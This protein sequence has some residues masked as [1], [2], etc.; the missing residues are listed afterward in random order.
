MQLYLPLTK[1]PQPGPRRELYQQFED[2]L[3]NVPGLEA[4]AVATSPP[5]GGGFGRGLAL[6]GRMPADGE[7]PPNVVVVAVGD[8]YFDTTGIPIRRGRTFRRD[9][10]LP[11]HGAAIV[12]ERF[13]A[14]H[15]PKQDPIGRQIRFIGDPANEWVPIVGVVPNVRQQ[16][17]RQGQGQP[18]P[19]AYIPLRSSPERTSVVLFRTPLDT[20]KAVDTIRGELRAIEPDLPLFNV[21]TLDQ[22]LAQQQWT[23]VVFG[24]MFAVF[25]GIALVLSAVGL[26]AVTAYSVSQRTQEIGIRMA[27]GALPS[28]ILWLV[29]RRS[30]VQL[31][32]GLPIGVAGA[33]GVGRL[34]Q[35]LL[36]QTSPNDPVTLASITF[37]LV[38]VAVLACLWP[39]RRAARFDPMLAL[40]GD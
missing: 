28:Q 5:M 15:S 4:S 22:A 37:L 21:Q 13:V 35:S 36:V 3:G 19:V 11:G 14:V 1:Y 32:I 30:L 29:L 16:G 2:R 17:G 7:Q 20:A 31:A 12:N 10:G 25:A 23:F 8:R 18:D 34:L 9:D 27:L 6:D 24:S 39:A 26:Y 40:R 38:A 33:F